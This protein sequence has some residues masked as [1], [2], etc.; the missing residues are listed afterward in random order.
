[1]LAG[2]TIMVSI[3][4]AFAL[5]IGMFIIYNSFAIAVTQR[6]S[7]IGILR[8]LGATRRQVRWLFLGESAV[9][10]CV[11]SLLG[12]GLGMLIAQATS[13]AISGIAGDLYGVAQQATE[14]ATRPV[15]L[16]LAVLAGVA[17]SLVAAVVPARNA[18]N[19]DP[20]QALQKGQYQVVSVQESRVRVILAAVAGGVAVACLT[21]TERRPL[22]YAG[23]AFALAGAVLLAPLVSARLA[24]TL[25]PVLTFLRPVEGALAA[26]SLIQAPRR[27]SATVLALMLSLALIVAF[28]GMA[29]A[30]YGSVVDWMQTSLNP[31][32]FVMPSPRLDL[33]TLRFPADMAAEIKAVPGVERV[34]MYR[35]GRIT[36]RGV[37]VMAVALEMES[38]AATARSRPVSGD[39][40]K[41][42][43]QAAAGEGVIVSDNLAQRLQL[44]FGEILEIPAPYGTIRLPIVGI[45]VDYT[46]QQGAVFMDRTLWVRHWQDDSVN[47]FRVFLAPD[48]A[49]ADV[50]QRIVDRYAGERQ[51]FVLTSDE[52]RSYVLRIT[53]QWFGLMTVQVAVAVFVAILGIVNTLTVSI[54]D[55]RR[56]LGVLQAVGALRGQIRRTIWLEALAVATLG[57]ILGCA[58]GALNLYYVL[59]I[60]QRDVAGLRLD[61]EYPVTTVLTLIPAILG[62]AFAAAIWPAESALRMPLVEA[63][64]YE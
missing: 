60:V 43:H 29:R 24:R 44:G 14:V 17:T 63:L 32:L 46:D 38:V 12:L 53:D 58:V 19:V 59:D 55:R 18:A 16:A 22:F 40:A 25:R 30:S 35:N 6:R 31:D 10:G 47:D 41:M 49:M 36:F 61:Y 54:A 45:I 48:A 62:A 57:V 56:E 33:R 52:S 51:L 5:F 42:Y 28:A 34:Q 64:E 4:S 26:D 37:P 13:A 8:A 20:V 27:T 50:R 2:Y 3:S 21:A 39:A 7:E 15:V 23:Y 9:L 1:M 11:G